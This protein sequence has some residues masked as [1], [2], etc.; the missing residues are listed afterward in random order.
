MCGLPVLIWSNRVLKSL[1]SCINWMNWKW[2]TT[3]PTSVL[4]STKM[5]FPITFWNKIQI[6]LLP[7]RV[8]SATS[9]RMEPKMFKSVNSG[10]SQEFGPKS[11]LTQSEGI[12]RIHSF[13]FDCSSSRKSTFC[14]LADYKKF[15]L[16][17]HGFQPLKWVFRRNSSATFTTTDL[18]SDRSTNSSCFFPNLFLNIKGNGT[19]ESLKSTKLDSKTVEVRTMNRRGRRWSMFDWTDGSEVEVD[20]GVRTAFGINNSIRTW[21]FALW[22]FCC[23]FCFCCRESCRNLVKKCERF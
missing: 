11:Q 5:Q 7:G 19:D 12:D 1:S 3:A 18:S 9:K 10:N 4:G 14:I 21:A 17:P 20:E 2:S 8:G 23:W 6:I 13:R 15:C 16:D 22:S